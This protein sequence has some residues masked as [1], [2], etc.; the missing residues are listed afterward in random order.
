MAQKIAIRRNEL[1]LIWFI[2]SAAQIALPDSF[3]QSLGQRYAL[4]ENAAK[5][6]RSEFPYELTSAFLV[7]AKQHQNFNAASIREVK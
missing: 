4:P 1:F 7:D 2:D 5:F 3:E 6:L